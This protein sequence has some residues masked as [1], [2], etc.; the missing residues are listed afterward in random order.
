MR[1]LL[2]TADGGGNVPVLVSVAAELVRRGHT[3]RVLAGPYFPGAPRSEPLEAK[4][5]AAGCEVV[6]PEAAAWLDGAGPMPDITAIPEHLQMLRTMA[7]YATMCVPWAVET[8]K[9]IESFRPELVLADLIIPARQRRRR[10][11]VFPA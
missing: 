11:P 3:V 5:T 4:F 6:T 7:I 8:A 2:C 1:I 9:E 10:R